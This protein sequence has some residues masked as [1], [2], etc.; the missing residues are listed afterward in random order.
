MGGDDNGKGKRRR[1]EYVPSACSECGEEGDHV[2]FSVRQKEEHPS[3]RRCRICM[4]KAQIY[5]GNPTRPQSETLDGPCSVCGGTQLFFSKHQQAVKA[6]SRKCVDCVAATEGTPYAPIVELEPG[7]V[8]SEHPKVEKRQGTA[9]KGGGRPQACRDF[10]NGTCSRE[11]CK[12]SHDLEAS[13]A[14]MDRFEFDAA[15]GDD[16]VQDHSAE[17]DLR[18]E[19]L[20][21][22]NVCIDFVNG[23]CGR[24]NCKYAHILEED[25]GL[26]A[27]TPGPRIAVVETE[28]KRRKTQTIFPGDKGYTPPGEKPIPKQNVAEEPC[29][30]CG[31]SGPEVYYSNRQIALP[32]KRRKCIICM[33]FES[34]EVQ[35]K[36]AAAMPTPKMPTLNVSM[37]AIPALQSGPA[38]RGGGGPAFGG[39]GTPLL[40]PTL[41][42]GP[43]F[44]GIPNGD[45]P[46]FRGGGDTPTFRGGGDTPAFRGG[47]DPPKPVECVE[48]CSSCGLCGALYSKRQSILPADKRK[49]LK[50]MAPPAV[51]DPEGQIVDQGAIRTLSGAPPRKRE[52]SEI[53]NV[54]DSGDQV[55]CSA[56]GSSD[57]QFSKRQQKVPPQQRKCLAC[58]GCEGPGPAPPKLN[59]APDP[60][61]QCGQTGVSFSNR[62]MQVDAAKRRCIDCMA[63]KEPRDKIPL[64]QAEQAVEPPAI[65][66]VDGTFLM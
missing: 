6:A 45:T 65:T 19:D 17:V 32:A 2:E 36:G 37:A 10:L 1:K 11:S 21:K 22:K 14:S 33:G 5:K 40:L 35:P 31:A 55:P 25:T 26:V 3:R 60:C 47:G 13:V 30:G 24:A 41:I 29:S 8:P 44:R 64:H 43:A 58:M 27:V 57:V 56:C 9:K 34:G 39:T 46:A 52:Y 20:K 62:Q 51:W 61:S 7:Y 50:C 66:P 16:E 28:G 63:V 48:P 49:C 54:A 23:K 38:F 12:F 42:G 53:A 4:E 15:I 18:R 59:A